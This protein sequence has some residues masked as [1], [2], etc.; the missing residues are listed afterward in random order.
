[1]IAWASGD[2]S[3]SR[4]WSRKSRILVAYVSLQNEDT[5]MCSTSNKRTVSSE[6][7]KNSWSYMMSRSIMM[8]KTW[9]FSSPGAFCAWLRK[10][11]KELRAIFWS[12]NESAFVF[13]FKTLLEEAAC[14]NLGDEAAKAQAN[15][16]LL[17]HR[18]LLAL[19]RGDDQIAQDAFESRVIFKGLR[20]TESAF[21]TSSRSVLIK[22]HAINAL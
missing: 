1:M 11:W 16:C 18:K 13:S 6:R 21:K 2:S 3:D 5:S 9:I 22:T 14:T 15:K 20:S 10:S 19:H 4:I 17:P 8:R 7:P 12:T